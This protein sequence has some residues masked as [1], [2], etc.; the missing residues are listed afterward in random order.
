VE[1]TGTLTKTAG[2]FVIDDP[3]APGE[4]TLAHATVHS[5]ERL[6]V[7]TGTVVLDA[8]GEA[9]VELPEWFGEL[10]GDARYQLTPIGAPAPRLHVAW[11]IVDG[12]F[13]IAGGV[14]GQKVSWQ[15]TAVRRDP[16][17]RA[18]PFEVRR[19]KAG[20]RAGTYLHPELYG[21]EER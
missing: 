21:V 19:V 2:A 11:E 15:I 1:V 6:D 20:D 13:G 18:H 17:A 12:R 14:P 9:V 16:W 10:N 4:R 3:A 5:S 7:Y 8:A